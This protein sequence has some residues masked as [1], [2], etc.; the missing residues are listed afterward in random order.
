MLDQAFLNAIMAAPWDDAPRLIAADWVDENGGEGWQLRSDGKLWVLPICGTNDV[1]WVGDTF[2]AEIGAVDKLPRCV[3]P[4]WTGQH[5]QWLLLD[6]DG[7][8]RCSDCASRMPVPHLESLSK[9]KKNKTARLRR[10]SKK[11]KLATEC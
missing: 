6:A 4:L 2:I 1:L 11:E 5:S 3:G 9:F 7:L 10:K 8:W